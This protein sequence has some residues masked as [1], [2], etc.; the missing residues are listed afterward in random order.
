MSNHPGLELMENEM[1]RQC[2][3]ALQT[4]NQPGSAVDQIV[5]S[6]K[7]TGRLILYAMG[8]SQHVN[9]IVEPLYRELGIDARSMI[10]SEQLLAPMPDVA[11]TALIASQ[12]GESGE[13][14]QLLATD[15]GREQRFGLTLEANSTLA[16]SVKSSIVAAG[17]TEHAF[18]ATRSIVLTLA[19]HAAILEALG[20]S[21]E[22]LRAV[23]VADSAPD[24]STVAEHVKA[25]DVFVFAG[26]HA[27]QGTAESAALSMMELARVPAIGFEGGQFRHGPFEFLRPGLGIFLLRSSGP[28]RPLA[29]SVVDTALQAGCT[30]VLLDASGEAAPAGCLHI[31][32]LTSMGLAASV[33]VILALQRLNILLAKQR[34]P[35]GIGTPRFTSKVTA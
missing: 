15:A 23:L 6:I 33:S 20:A 1:S 16:R 24:M 17:G 9:R 5:S 26:W 31:K 11:R 4:M 29:A 27:M 7:E 30:V 32:L 19:M 25:C 21:Q 8:G 14:K 3:D 34:I 18:A 28:D 2:A 12:S 10:A 35:S 13:I 22:A